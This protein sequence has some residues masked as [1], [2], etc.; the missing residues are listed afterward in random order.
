MCDEDSA[1]RGID[2]GSGGAGCD[3]EV[4]YASLE[5]VREMLVVEGEE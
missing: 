3:F 4:N 2:D 1:D 5:P